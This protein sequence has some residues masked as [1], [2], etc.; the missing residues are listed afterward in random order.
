MCYRF[1]TFPFNTFPG[2]RRHSRNQTDG[3]DSSNTD[4]ELNEFCPSPGPEL[5]AAL[6]HAS[7]VVGG[8]GSTPSSSC[9]GTPTY[10]LLPGFLPRGGSVE[11]TDDGELPLYL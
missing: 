3:Q 8:V 10:G 7:A 11:F 1:L 5:D 6:F 4:S 9:Q 2:R